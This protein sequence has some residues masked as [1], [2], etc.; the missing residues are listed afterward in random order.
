[1]DGSWVA[2]RLMVVAA[3]LMSANMTKGA[4]GI[5]VCNMSED[6]LMACKPS[7]TQPNPT[8]PTTEC[9]NAVSNAD[10]QC[11]CSYKNSV[12]LPFLGIDP[13]LAI[14]LPAKCNL[15]TPVGC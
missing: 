15:Q 13:D 5:S 7:V 6:G 14:S 8:D 1:M 10:L 4:S 3:V 2:L 11:L 9:C 12:E